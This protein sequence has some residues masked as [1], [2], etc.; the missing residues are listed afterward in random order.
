[1]HSKKIGKVKLEKP[2]LKISKSRRK[3]K[4]LQTHHP[5]GSLA[6]KKT[7]ISKLTFPRQI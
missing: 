1:M 4:H 3:L 6:I 5:K 7:V 2:I